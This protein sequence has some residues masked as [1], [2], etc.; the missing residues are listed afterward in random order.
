MLCGDLLTP[1][2]VVAWKGIGQPAPTLWQYWKNHRT[3]QWASFYARKHY[4]TTGPFCHSQCAL[5]HLNHPKTLTDNLR[6]QGMRRSTM[7]SLSAS[8]ILNKPG[9]TVKS[10]Q[11]V[12]TPTVGDIVVATWMLKIHFAEPSPDSHHVLLSQLTIAWVRSTR[13]PRWSRTVL[14][15]TIG[16]VQ[17][18]NSLKNWNTDP[19]VRHGKQPKNWGQIDTTTSV[20]EALPA[21]GWHLV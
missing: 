20:P 12:S 7:M 9:L 1:L 8:I 11:S 13:C 2:R 15:L 21:V 10:S 14:Q 16:L 4:T 17:F 5:Y 6:L 18:H 3:V 19:Y